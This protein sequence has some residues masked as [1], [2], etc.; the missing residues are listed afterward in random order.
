MEVVIPSE[1]RL[2]H[3]QA[4]LGGMLLEMRQCESIESREFSRS[5]GYEIHLREKWVMANWS[6]LSTAL[7][8]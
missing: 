3:D 8:S 2:F 5:R 7:K 6:R 1:A 4:H